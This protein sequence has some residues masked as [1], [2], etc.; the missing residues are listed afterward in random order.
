MV[1]FMMLV[2]TVYYKLRWIDETSVNR[3]NLNKVGFKVQDLELKVNI[4]T[5]KMQYGTWPLPHHI[6]KPGMGNELHNVRLTLSNSEE[7]NSWIKHLLL[8]YKSNKQ[9]I[10]LS[11]IINYYYCL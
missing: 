11:M 8:R 5:Y 2:H 10:E 9:A 4:L 6:G 3:E 1:V 7:R